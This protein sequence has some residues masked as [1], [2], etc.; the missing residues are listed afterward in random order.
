MQVAKGI[1][2]FFFFFFAPLCF[3]DSC[4]GVVG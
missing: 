3:I 2:F 4:F 1:L